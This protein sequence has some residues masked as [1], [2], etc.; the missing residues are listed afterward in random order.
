MPSSRANNTLTNRTVMTILLVIVTA[1]AFSPVLTAGYINCDDRLYVTENPYVQAGLTNESIR[2]A[3]TALHA[4]NWH[5]LTWLSHMLDIRLFGMNPTGHHLT[6]LLLHLANT[7]LLAWLLKRLTGAFW[8]SWAVAALFALHPLHVESVAWVA[9]RKDVLSAFFWLITMVCY[10]RFARR[11]ESGTY[12]LTCICFILGLLAKPMVVTLPIV[13]LLLDFWPLGRWRREA[14]PSIGEAAY[15]SLPLSRLFLEK[16]PLLAASAAA[17]LVT[18]YAQQSSLNS[19]P[20]LSRVLN[21]I[22][23]YGAYMQ[24]TVWPAGLSIFYPLKASIPT[25][26]VALSLI[27]LLSIALLC[28]AGFRKYPYLA[29]GWLWYLVTLIPVIGL[30]QVGEQ[31]M[32][33][34]YTY[35]PSIGL[36][37]MLSWGAADIA[38]KFRLPN[39][40]VSLFA[41]ALMLLLA[42]LTF[43]QTGYW[44]DSVALF[45]HALAVTNR[46]C[47]AHNNLGAALM[48][49]RDYQAALRQFNDSLD[50]N[51][52]DSDVWTNAGIIYCSTGRYR[53]AEKALLQALA[54]NPDN[55]LAREYLALAYIFRGD[56][57]PARVEI[58]ALE[59]VD[60]AAADRIRGYVS[61]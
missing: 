21:A 49:N 40:T 35:L 43:R 9:E 28:M 16:L 17:S 31:A 33:D 24:K 42:A 34:R 48:R 26:Q 12:I 5:P 22:Y 19:L 58:Q 41:G 7:M 11:P 15:P 46:N 37:I 52:S 51:P 54:L 50:I 29:I 44:H 47:L 2:W 25:W 18:Y 32:A 30:I 59:K 14:S 4:N 6:S 56:M 8:R 38:E 1:A 60:R 13:L 39:R 23:S 10:E 20:F 55:A 45:S 36:F 53:E 27:L 61:N 3:F 57:G